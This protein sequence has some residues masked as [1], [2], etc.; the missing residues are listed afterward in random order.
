MGVASQNSTLPSAI[1]SFPVSLLLTYLPFFYFLSFIWRCRFFRVLFV[2]FP[3]SL[4]EY[5]IVIR[6]FLPTANGVFLPC[7]HGL[8]FLHQLM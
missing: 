5:V 3:L 7:D 2:P 4:G 6:S 1:T 8:D